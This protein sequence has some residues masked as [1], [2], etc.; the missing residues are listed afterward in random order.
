[1]L[2]DDSDD[3]TAGGEGSALGVLLAAFLGKLFVSGDFV[4][5]NSGRL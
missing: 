3:V 4:E 1:M 5:S 2:N